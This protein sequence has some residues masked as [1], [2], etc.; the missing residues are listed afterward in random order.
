M[1]ETEQSMAAGR[2]PTDVAAER[3]A[4]AAKASGSA[5]VEGDGLDAKTKDELLEE[6][7]A[8]GVEVKTSASKAEILTALRA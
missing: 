4:A 3:A 5:P 6:A 2:A 8:R 1:S 7:E